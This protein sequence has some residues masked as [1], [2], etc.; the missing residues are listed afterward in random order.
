MNNNYLRLI[1]PGLY[2]RP[3][4]IGTFQQY[5]TTDIHYHVTCFGKLMA[6]T[7][8]IPEASILARQCSPIMG[9]ISGL[10]F[11]NSDEIYH[12]VD[13]EYDHLACKL[14]TYGEEAIISYDVLESDRKVA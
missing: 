12:H 11:T 7:N 13:S 10:W 4:L 9:E 3:M 6:A 5:I 8:T 14:S 1:D 2:K